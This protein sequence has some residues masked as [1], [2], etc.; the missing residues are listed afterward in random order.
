MSNNGLSL[1]PSLFP[2][3]PPTCHFSL[4]SP[5]QR[6]RKLLSFSLNIRQFLHACTFGGFFLQNYSPKGVGR[7][8]WQHSWDWECC[9]NQQIITPVLCPTSNY[10]QLTSTTCTYLRQNIARVK[11]EQRFVHHLKFGMQHT[12]ARGRGDA[13]TGLLGNGQQERNKATPRLRVSVLLQRLSGKSYLHWQHHNR[14]HSNKCDAAECWNI[15][16]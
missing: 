6:T 1:C 5:T 2:S 12:E 11:K 13:R 14:L 16:F 3:L 8:K 9:K 10:R 15:Y 4:G 7:Q